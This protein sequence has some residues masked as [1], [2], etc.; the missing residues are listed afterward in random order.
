MNMKEI[1]TLGHSTHEAG[2]FDTLLE[3]HGIALLA[4][5]RALPRS[6]RVPHADGDALAA[7]LRGHGIRYLHLP[8]LGGRRRALPD[9]PNSG[10]QNDA[11][12]GYAD[13]MTSEEFAAGLERLEPAATRRRAAVM[14]AEALWWRCHRRLVADALVVGGWTVHH[15]GPDGRLTQHDLTDFAHVENGTLS[16]PSPQQALDV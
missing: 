3:R 13:H 11:F 9:S 12:R 2:A 5:V 14:C 7:R 1:F 4:D 16:Y 6:R 15:I 8:E 10:W